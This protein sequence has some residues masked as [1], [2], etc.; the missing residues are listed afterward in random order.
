MGV[1]LLDGNDGDLAAVLAVILAVVPN[2]FA[3]DAPPL[4][5][6]A[7]AVDVTPKDFPVNMVGLF[8]ANMAEKATDPL[9]ARPLASRD[10]TPPPAPLL[11]ALDYCYEQ[12]WND[13]WPVNQPLAVRV[14]DGPMY[15]VRPTGV[16]SATQPS[17]TRQLQV[18]AR[19]D[20]RV[21]ARLLLE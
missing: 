12:G 3:D 17:T 13:A 4:R 5:A 11:A 6:G 9:F 16:V 14:V 18:S 2:A 7:A 15:H 1:D 21:S 20:H 10:G 8:G 19:A